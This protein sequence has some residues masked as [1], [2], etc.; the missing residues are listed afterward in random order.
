MI[1]NDEPQNFQIWNKS[2]ASRL[3]EPVLARILK[4]RA[5]CV[6]ITSAAILQL[7]LGA[8][9]LPAW[10][11]LLHSTFGI[12]DFG[13]GL[14]RAILA[15]L[16]G[17]WQTSLMFHAFAPLFVVALTLVA[18]AAILP[19]KLRAETVAWVETIERRTGLTAILLS[20]LVLYWLARLLIMGE[21]FILLVS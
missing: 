1:D 8:L 20:G 11:S 10:R 6:A 16:R 12:P 17:D 21:A 13:C 9:G 19:D 18:L 14:T 2:I 15:L 5:T 4:S 3:R 7:S